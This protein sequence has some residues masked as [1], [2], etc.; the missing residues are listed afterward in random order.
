MADAFTLS[1]RTHMTPWTQDCVYYVVLTV[2][3]RGM[4]VAPDWS[5][6]GLGL[7]E[8]WFTPWGEVMS[9][10]HGH[11]PEPIVRLEFATAEGQTAIRDIRVPSAVEPPFAGQAGPQLIEAILL[12]YQD[13]NSPP[14][15]EQVLHRL[16]AGQARSG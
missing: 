14:S 6:K 10:E 13:A 3:D 5:K 7:E 9:L 16:D 2:S 1:F 12:A 15:V 11:M 4:G 8:E